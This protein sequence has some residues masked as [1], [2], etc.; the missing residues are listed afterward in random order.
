MNPWMTEADEAA[1]A[2][3]EAIVLSQ[4]PADKAW[5]PV[6]DYSFEGREP[7]ERPHAQLIKDVLVA[8]VADPHNPH[9][10]VEVFD[11]GCGPGHLVRILREM[12]VNAYGADTQRYSEWFDPYESRD[13]TERYLDWRPVFSVCDVTDE[14]GQCCEHGA[15][16][17]ADIVVCREVLEHLPLDTIRDAV[18]NLCGA[19]GT[20]LYITTRFTPNPTSMLAVAQSDDL[21]PTHITMM[22][23][24]FLR[25]LIVLEGFKR[26]AD[27]EEKLDWQQKGR[28]LV[29]ER[30]A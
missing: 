9:K 25:A 21:D 18:S 2:Q 14:E 20:F 6:T 5:T 22:N 23:Q 17:Y 1:L 19:A 12:G 10:G 29:Y 13:P 7:I 27:L 28:C 4:K 15:W 30:V 26:R 16:S 3:F 8:A 11:F 24:A